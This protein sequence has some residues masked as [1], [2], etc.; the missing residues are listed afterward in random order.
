MVTPALC[1]VDWSAAIDAAINQGAL[2]ADELPEFLSLSAIYSVDLETGSFRLR[3]AKESDPFN[4][5]HET[6]R[7]LLLARFGDLAGAVAV[8]EKLK[9]ILPSAPVLHYLRALF[10]LR[11]GSPDQAR[12]ICGTL[13]TTHPGFVHGKFLRAEA[14]IVMGPRPAAAD[15]YLGP[16]PAGQ[17]WDPLWADLLV[18]LMLFYPQDGPS[19]AQKYLTKKV[20]TDSASWN[21]VN[22]AMH[23]VCADPEELGLQLDAEKVGSRGEALVLERL[24]DVLRRKP[25]EISFRAIDKLHE[26]YPRR[27]TLRRIYD[28]F[29]ARQAVELSAA[30]R[31]E[32]ALCFVEH[33]MRSQPHDIV[34]YQNR[35]VLFTLLRDEEHYHEAWAAHNRHQYRLALL[36]AFDGKYI[37]NIILTHR[38]FAQQARYSPYSGIHPLS[39]IFRDV[40]GEGEKPRVT[41]NSAAIAAD[42]DLLRQWIHHTGAELVFRHARLGVDG[43]QVFLDPR[44]RDEATSRLEA[45]SEL[46]NSLGILVPYEGV[47]LAE[48]L[49]DRWRVAVTVVRTRYEPANV[50]PRQT[51]SI[52]GAEDEFGPS[53]PSSSEVEAL[54]RAHLQALADVCLMCLQWE[55]NYQQM[56]LAEELLG[57]ACAEGTFFDETVVYRVEKEAGHQTPFAIQV[58]S[59]QIKLI[60]SGEKKQ[61]LT[62]EQRRSVVNGC[63]AEL[64][65]EMGNVTYSGYAG[66]PK[67]GATRAM[68]YVERARSYRPADASIELT[69]AKLLALGEFFDE[70]RVALERF[71]RLVKPDNAKAI[72]SADK[73]DELLR[74]KHN[75]GKQGNK[76]QRDLDA[77][78]SEVR[79]V[80]IR[81]L[82]EELD[83]SPSAWRLYEELVNELTIAGRFSEAVDCADRS[84]ARCLTRSEQMH[85]RELAIGA[86]G[87][88]RLA[89]SNPRAARLYG[90]GAHEPARKV[91]EA[92]AQNNDYTLLYL[93]GRCLLASGDPMK[94]REMFRA[95]A[96]CC[97][98]QLHRTALRHLSENIDNAYLI[99]ARTTLNTALADDLVEQALLE[100][101][102]VFSRLE[103]PGAW[104]V[105]FARV[106]YTAALDCS[107]TKSSPLSPPA[108]KVPPEWQ[109]RFSEALNTSNDADRALRLC[110]LAEDVHPFSTRQA[111]TLRARIL[112]LKRQLAAADALNHSGKL[113][114]ERRFD[115][116]LSFLDA[117]DPDVLGQPR[118]QRIRVLALM[119]LHRFDEADKV[120]AGIGDAG[121]SDIREFVANYAS[122][123]CRQRIAKAQRLL[124]E[125]RPF[126]AT[127]VL[128]GA[129]PT[130]HKEAA[131]VAYC[132]AYAGTLNGYQ[133][134]RQGQRQEAQSCFLAA[135]NHIEPYLQAIDG[136][137]NGHIVELFDRLEK[138][139]D[140][141][142]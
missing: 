52:E 82:E 67:E 49:K 140:S 134:L 13:E 71:R 53:T 86:R 137:K 24:V 54:Q 75:E 114:N 111:Q 96:E 76:R 9:E 59:D 97:P 69:A 26:Q 39:S 42:P 64:L 126:D 119:G 125:S 51:E 35:A 95:S 128:L 124:K 25:S 84:V 121:G 19:V 100:A 11:M 83:Q 4:P 94:A 108:I 101:A 120:V 28:L 7:A 73:L 106:F 34:Y 93:L 32:Q 130:T 47:R 30:G 12:A 40:I 15:R 89:E 57:F 135:L 127:T 10:A 113:I 16:L 141:R 55:P 132:L 50:T 77:G 107:G 20:T 44:D 123:V 56:W 60:G 78:L 36:G 103:D 87:I 1:Q 45:L 3:K 68:K 112:I 31:H 23:W 14:Q 110:S 105:D 129:K 133:L 61:Q 21:L 37:E 43:M 109:Q 138:E 33:S 88:S 58:L 102:A 5:L 38:L 115:D 136:V 29:L 62:P 2:T 65:R 8:L 18:K 98:R 139:L 90:L 91:I 104:L 79:D 117:Q 80:R 131:D 74:E 70:A 72:E 22:R 142:G 17:E 66:E 27:P 48:Y 99:V 41:T 122:L 85:A 46:S 118:L 6:R 116:A 63:M 81:E 92:I